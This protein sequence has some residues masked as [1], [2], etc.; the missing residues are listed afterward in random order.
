[1]SPKI[2]RE[3]LLR[4]E[5]QLL[6]ERRRGAPV[7]ERHRLADRDR[8]VGGRGRLALPAESRR[9]ASAICCW[10]SSPSTSSIRS[11][12]GREV[13]L[14]LVDPFLSGDQ[15]L[16]LAGEAFLGQ[17]GGGRRGRP[18][19]RR[20]RS[21]AAR[22]A[23]KLLEAAIEV[24]VALRGV[25]EVGRELRGTGGGLGGLTLGGRRG[26]GEPSDLGLVLLDRPFGLPSSARRASGARRQAAGPRR[27]PWR[28]PAPPR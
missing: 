26:L 1:M 10:R 22:R 17:S 21:P 16:G 20:P 14:Q 23:S 11:E 4:V 25:L 19:P 5:R 7:V 3:G 24:G 13:T 6:D 12:L 27:W 8:V 9:I 15:F 28:S 18:G 2:P